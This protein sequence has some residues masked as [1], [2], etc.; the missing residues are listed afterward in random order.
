MVTGSE[1]YIGSVL[2]PYLKNEGFDVTGYD[3]GFFKDCLLYDEK[4]NNTIKKDVRDINQ[5]EVSKVDAVVHL[6]GISND[7]LK[8]LSGDR[9]YNPT[10][11]YSSRLAKICKEEGKKFIF[12][13]SCSIYGKGEE[14]ILTEESK[15]NPQTPY[16]INKLQ[17]EQDLK[18]LSGQGFSPIA[19]RFSTLYGLSPRMRF[20][21]VI[22]MFAGMATSSKEIILNSDGKAWRPNL[23]ILDACKAIR[24]SLEHTP[25]KDGLLTLNVG[26]NSQ[27]YR[28]IDLAEAVKKN[29]DGCQISFMNEKNETDELIKDRKVQDGVDTRTYVVSF[30]KIN[31]SLPGFSCEYSMSNGI[32]GLVQGLENLGLTRDKFRDIN[33]YRLQKMENLFE[34][35]LLTEELIWK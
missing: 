13:S 9:V 22:N 11:E 35:G 23:H 32:E 21:I 34:K 18:G 33:F 25:K 27:N 12:A 6:A 8:K 2:R 20:D 28:I 16:S 14:E 5:E 10:R 26:N 30:D 3:V 1:G 7:P 31:S 4:E 29:V 15:T 19:L 24:C 17:I